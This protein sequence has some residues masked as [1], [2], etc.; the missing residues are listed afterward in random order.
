MGKE[1]ENRVDRGMCITE[2]LCSKPES[3][4]CCKSTRI[5]FR[6]KKFSEKNICVFLFQYVSFLNICFYS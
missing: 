5:Q 6:K 4:T 2:S 3:N 1:T